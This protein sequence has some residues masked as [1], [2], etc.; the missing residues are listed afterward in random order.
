M[1][2]TAALLTLPMA[3]PAGALGEAVGD[4]VNDATDTVSDTV[5]ETVSGTERAVSG[6]AGDDS[7]GDGGSA[8]DGLGEAVNTATGTVEEVTEGV[9][10]VVEK[11]AAGDV[12]GAVESTSQA[13][14]NTVNTTSGAVEDVVSGLP[15]QPGAEASD[16]DEA[17]EIPEQQAEPSG[18]TRGGTAT[19]LEPDQAFADR[20]V[21]TSSGFS[22][23]AAGSPRAPSAYNAPATS[24]LFDED[25]DPEAAEEDRLRSAQD[26]DIA[27]L[28]S[29]PS[30][31]DGSGPSVA[32]VPGALL[33]TATALLVL[34]GAG[35]ALHGLRRLDLG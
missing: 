7:G 5:N 1:G 10:E 33:A 34:V 23:R 28:S 30:P 2:L 6:A 13:V 17:V 31:G 21:S 11:A 20:S 26:P 25:A 32:G 18:P 8:G 14:D 16:G 24:G 3:A 15:A 35:H 27:S 9:R 22:P 19:E 29:V 4:A 12:E